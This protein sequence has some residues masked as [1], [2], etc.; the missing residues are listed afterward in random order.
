MTVG[1]RTRRETRHATPS[2]RATATHRHRHQPAHGPFEFLRGLNIKR[3]SFGP[4]DMSKWFPILYCSRIIFFNVFTEILDEKKGERNKLPP[5]PPLPFPPP[6]ECRPALKPGGICGGGC[7]S[8]SAIIISIFFP[9]CLRCQFIL[10]F[11]K[12]PTWGSTAQALRSGNAA[13]RVA[14][15]SALL[16]ELNKPRNLSEVRFDRFFALNPCP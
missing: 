10:N 5:S 7:R 4:L 9:I 11:E 14:E 16:S 12:H 3:S 6:I 1:A 15:T 8:N 13:L 2:F